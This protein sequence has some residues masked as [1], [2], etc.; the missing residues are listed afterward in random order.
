MVSWSSSLFRLWLT[1]LGA[2]YC[3]AAIANG[4]AEKPVLLLADGWGKPAGQT[5][6][7]G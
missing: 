1:R 6:E 3:D 7:V 5:D 4:N 2:R